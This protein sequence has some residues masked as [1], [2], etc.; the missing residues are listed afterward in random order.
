MQLLFSCPLDAAQHCIRHGHHYRLNNYSASYTFFD[1][2][3]GF[4]YSFG[5]TMPR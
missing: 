5:P 3:E 2:I 1:S 4:S